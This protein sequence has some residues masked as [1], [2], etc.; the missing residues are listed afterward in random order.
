MRA[1]AVCLLIGISSAPALATEPVKKDCHKIF[2][3][4]IVEE[5]RGIPGIAELGM[6]VAKMVGIA[7]RP[8]EKHGRPFWYFYDACGVT[9]VAQFDRAAMTFSLRAIIFENARSTKSGLAIGDPL[10]RVIELYG[11]PTKFRGS[12]RDPQLE[13]YVS[14]DAHS[15]RETPLEG[16]AS[17]TRSGMY[18][19]DLHTLFVGSH[20]KVRRIVVVQSDDPLPSWLRAAGAKPDGVVIDPKV[21]APKWDGLVL[22]LPPPPDVKPLRRKGLRA[23]APKDWKQDGTRFVAPEGHEFV[24]L[25]LFF[26]AAPWKAEIAKFPRNSLPRA[27]RTLPARFLKRVGATAGQAIEYQSPRGGNA[28][29][30]LRHYIIAI[31]NHGAYAVVEVTRTATGAM[32][33]PDGEELARRVFRAVHLD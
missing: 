20:G 31:R 27:L 4:K 6:T 13:S 10:K 28:G 26:D 33:S 1:F 29:M 12:V 32:A 16:D 2:D 11:N 22:R 14:I 7:G 15:G 21:S 19:P 18:Y 25:E 5:G 30:P 8:M 17:A 24:R 9:A 23:A 3:G